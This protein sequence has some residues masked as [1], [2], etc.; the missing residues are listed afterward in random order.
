IQQKRKS[1]KANQG[2]PYKRFCYIIFHYYYHLSASRSPPFVARVTCSLTLGSKM[3]NPIVISILVVGLLVGGGYLLTRPTPLAEI[4]QSERCAEMCDRRDSGSI[5][6]LEGKTKQE[7]R[8]ILGDP[9]N[10]DDEGEVWIWLFQWDDYKA[11]GLPTDW[12]TM[13]SN[14]P[15]DGLW[16]GFDS[17][18]R[19]S[20]FLYSLSAADPPAGRH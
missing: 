15:G 2:D 13:A 4:P 12:R 1:N 11:R 6:N 19:A 9:Q 17:S 7:I 16:I 8:R 14:S 5:R 18:D 3:K 10:H 20:T